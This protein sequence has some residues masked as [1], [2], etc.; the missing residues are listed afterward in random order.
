MG[1]DAIAIASASL[2][3]VACQQYKLCDKGQCPV[4][5]TTQDKRTAFQIKNRYWSKK[6][7]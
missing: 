4:G 2:I 6:I 7:N 5:V 3:A 1:A